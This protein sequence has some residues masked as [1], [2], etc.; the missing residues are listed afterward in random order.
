MIHKKDLL[1]LIADEDDKIMALDDNIK[2]L[3]T[4]LTMLTDIVEDM[5]N[6]VDVFPEEKVIRVAVAVPK[7]EKKETVKVKTKKTAKKTTAKKTAKK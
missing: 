2:I 4:K 6:M 5:V 1:D 3:D 7:K